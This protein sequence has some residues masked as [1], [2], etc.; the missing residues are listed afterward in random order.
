MGKVGCPIE[1]IND[2][3]PFSGARSGQSTGFLGKNRM[4]GIACANRADDESLALLVCGRHE[5]GATFQLNE[6]L[7]IRVVLENGTGFASQTNR[8]IEIFH[9]RL[10]HSCAGWCASL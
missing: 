5:V 4:V 9:L 1:R 3:L 6:L 7:A 2:P 8:K 10:F